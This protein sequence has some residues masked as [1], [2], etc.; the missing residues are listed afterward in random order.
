MRS[1]QLILWGL[2]VGLMLPGTVSAETLEKK[3]VEEMIQS[4]ENIKKA[5]IARNSKQNAVAL[6]AYTKNAATPV[7]ANA[8]FLECLK[9]VRFTDEGKRAEA[10]RKYREQKDDEFNQTY[11]R[12]AK[13]VELQYLILTIKAGRVEDRREMMSPLIKFVDQVLKLDGRAFEH[14]E[15]GESSLFVEA[16]DIGNT[17]DPGD[18]ELQPT[19][20]EGIY[21]KAILP[22]M[23]QHRDPRL[24]DAW[25]SKIKH[26][27]QY[28]EIDK[29]GR[30]RKEREEEREERRERGRG[31][32]GDEFRAEAREEQDPYK[33]FMEEDL[34]EM[35]WEMCEDL[36][37]HGF[38]AEALPLMLEVIRDH[39]EY[40]EIR[41][42]LTGLEND[43]KAALIKL[44]GG[45]LPT[46]SE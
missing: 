26:A 30:E 5:V 42:W 24:V 38:E 14:I 17:L 27:R 43:L 11:H 21:D 7:S 46:P 19:S 36:K 13:Q 28:A 8:F 29:V 18:W 3:D 15:G 22:H 20:I 9:K 25:K 6:R 44:N 12:A 35:K 33:D 31:R 16:Y 34:P 23:R 10:W 40:K 37:K 41:S 4:L 39:P 45:V 2:S 1:Y 32:T